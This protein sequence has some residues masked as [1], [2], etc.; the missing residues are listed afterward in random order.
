M[1]KKVEV[2]LKGIGK[3]IEQA[4]GKLS[5]ASRGLK[6]AVQKKKVVAK[7]K[8]LKKVKSE[9]KMICKGSY[10]IKVPTS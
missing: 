9:L 1:A 7:I 6:D 3:Q 2:S 10:N 8:A 4:E 5:A